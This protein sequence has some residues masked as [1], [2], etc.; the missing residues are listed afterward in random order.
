[1]AIDVTDAEEGKTVVDAEGNAV[2]TVADVEGGTALVEP[3][4]DLTDEVL[5]T[6]GLGNAD[7]D[8]MPV[9]SND[10]ESITDD[11]IQL[12]TTF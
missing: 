11:E 3:N 1:M 4:P 12:E 2:G 5:S 9:Q 8:N 7:A 6:L 10:I